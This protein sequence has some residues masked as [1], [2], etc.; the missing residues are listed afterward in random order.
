[1]RKDLTRTNAELAQRL[2]NLQD[3]KAKQKR[4]ALVEGTPTTAVTPDTDATRQKDQDIALAMNK[5]GIPAPPGGEPSQ[6]N[7]EIGMGTQDPMGQDEPAHEQPNPGP[8]EFGMTR[9]EDRRGDNYNAGPGAPTSSEQGGLDGEQK[10]HEG[11]EFEGFSDDEILEAY[12]LLCGSLEEAMWGL[13]IA[14]IPITEIEDVFFNGAPLTEALFGR[15]GGAIK[16][17][18]GGSTGPEKRS[19]AQL[20]SVI[21][22]HKESRGEGPGTT[23][24]SF[25]KKT[26]TPFS[27]TH[28]AGHDA[29]RNK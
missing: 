3:N 6:N 8:E 29:R 25:I 17:A 26:D 12:L 20:K 1:M 13:C 10:K 24:P 21:A 5:F 14:G 28:N 9:P 22:K 23:K 4:A 18:V 2:F 19:P 11:T 7:G 15:I 27:A 16:K